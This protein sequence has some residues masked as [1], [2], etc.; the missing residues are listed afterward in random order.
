MALVYQEEA[1]SASQI[2]DMENKMLQGIF[3][4]RTVEAV[5][6]AVAY[7]KYLSSVGLTSENYPVFLTMLEIENHWVIDAL[8][9]K[10]DPFLFLAP[11]QP[12]AFIVARILKMLAKWH[13]GN[14]YPKCLSVILGVLQSVYGAPKD[15]HRI[16]PLKIA[17]LNAIGKHLVKENGQGDLLNNT[18][19]KILDKVAQLEGEGDTN[20]EELAIHASAIRNAFFDNRKQMEDVLPS[21]LLKREDRPEEVEPR[22]TIRITTKN[23]KVKDKSAPVKKMKPKRAKQKKAA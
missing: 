16:Y 12:N 17:D 23:A 8:I 19:L 5:E 11:V 2:V 7:A 3:N 10:R 6:A 1:W 9:S 20:I 13:N 15:G 21:V 14:V 4:C 22:K 18:I